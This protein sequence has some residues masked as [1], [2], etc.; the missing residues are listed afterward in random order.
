MGYNIE[1]ISMLEMLVRRSLPLRNIMILIWKRQGKKNSR[2][3]LMSWK[4]QCTKWTAIDRCAEGLLGHLS[5]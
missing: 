2:K 5:R 1:L 3:D 4:L